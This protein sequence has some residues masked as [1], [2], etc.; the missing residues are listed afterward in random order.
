MT[1][2]END[3]SE[4]ESSV[5]NSKYESWIPMTAFLPCPKNKKKK[6]TICYYT[7][8][9]LLSIFLLFSWHYLMALTYSA[10]LMPNLEAQHH[11]SS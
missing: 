5:K 3:E 2:M 9:Q 8:N 7:D 4:V 6:P 11:A 10:S 1:Y